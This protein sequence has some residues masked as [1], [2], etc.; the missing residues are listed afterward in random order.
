MASHD[1]V[2]AEIERI[3]TRYGTSEGRQHPQGNNW[4][5][6]CPI[7]EA[8]KEGNASLRL[9]VHEQVN[10]PGEFEV[11]VKCGTCPDTRRN[12]ILSIM[13]SDGFLKET[14]PKSQNISVNF[15]PHDDPPWHSIRDYDQHWAY[16]DLEG[17]TKFW[18]VRFKDSK[19][20]RYSRCYSVRDENGKDFFEWSSK[21][22]DKLDVPYNAFLLKHRV[23]KPIVIVEGAKA[24]DAAMEA[25]GENYTF[26]C[27]EGSSNI[28]GFD[29]RCLEGKDIILFPDNDPP[30]LKCMRELGNSLLRIAKS[31]RIVFQQVRDDFPKGWDLADA[32]PDH[33]D[34]YVMITQAEE[35]KKTSDLDMIFDLEIEGELKKID[36]KIA[37]VLTNTGELVYYDLDQFSFNDGYQLVNK[38]M[39]Y[40]LFPQVCKSDKKTVK[41]VD[42]WLERP[43][44]K[45]Y[46]G[47]TYM[48]G[49]NRDVEYRNEFS[50]YVKLN[51][52]RGYAVSPLKEEASRS[53]ELYT[54]HLMVL[55]EDVASVGH[56]LD[57]LCHLVQFP[58]E[59]PH[60]SY[61]LMGQQGSGK[62]LALLPITKILGPGNSCS[63]FGS[64]LLREFNS[65]YGTKMFVHV[66]EAPSDM[67]TKNYSNIRNLITQ[68]EVMI[69][70]KGHAEYM[71]PS[72]HRLVMT[73]NP[74]VKIRLAHDD[75]RMAIIE[76]NS[77][78]LRRNLK[79]R[80]F[81]PDYFVKTRKLF[82]DSV[83]LGGL[84]AFFQARKI[85]DPGFLFD[86]FDTE[87]KEERSN[88]FYDPVADIIY[89][90]LY[91]AAM[92]EDIL[93][94]DITV[95]NIRLN[96]WPTKR[97]AYLP[98]REIF[99]FLKEKHP[100]LSHTAVSRRL[101]VFLDDTT[102]RDYTMTDFGGMRTSR[103]KDRC[104]VLD[105][106]DK[107]RERFDTVMRRVTTWPSLNEEEEKETKPPEADIVKLPD[108]NPET[109]KEELKKKPDA[110]KK[111]S[112][113]S[114]QGGNS[115]I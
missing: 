95:S 6:Y 114:P 36:N 104:F 55:M 65:V 59:K 97:L 35:F 66:D 27:G 75:R 37:T 88:D 38:D 80:I 14:K 3:V 73:A 25:Y 76:C 61:I 98:K 107:L 96:E 48:P 51:I 108:P 103:T 64:T 71:T 102:P 49:E 77:N 33:V 57:F 22:K 84:L 10:R 105:H 115:I 109:E 46:K 82:T 58:L 39:L 87:M 26:I 2:V 69:N 93:D 106:I 100:E 60:V 81:D 5:C 86:A 70:Q 91:D 47:L 29:W 99:R 13:R 74:D 21:F 92:P 17:R 78:Q 111:P 54:K 30:G 62:S 1:A 40:Q 34:P 68:E 31:V 89:D 16:C 20:K 15:P 67:F 32:A 7:H 43:K 53:G 41:L 23:G 11:G 12:D 72:Y 24:C 18:L 63:I 9:Y 19:G 42:L 85:A 83:F 52:F 45:I 50:T 101:G 112:G 28:M 44:K 4:Y 110:G 79:G 8:S 56:F 90:V 113:L 94:L